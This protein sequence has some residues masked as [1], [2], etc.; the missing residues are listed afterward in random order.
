[1]RRRA[2]LC[3]VLL[4]GP[5]ACARAERAPTPLPDALSDSTFGA[6]VARISEAPGYFDTDNLL[7]NESDT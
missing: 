1:V 4:A 6:L 2:L 3:A 7:S 5:L